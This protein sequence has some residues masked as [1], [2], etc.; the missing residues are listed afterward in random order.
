[1]S[2]LLSFFSLLSW[3]THALGSISHRVWVIMGLERR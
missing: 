2:T 3:M 1:M